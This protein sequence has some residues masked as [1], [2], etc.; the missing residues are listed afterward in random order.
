M[1][2]QNIGEAISI[3]DRIVI[4]TKRPSTV[5]KVYKITFE[6]K[7]SPTENRKEKEF[8]TYYNQLWKEIDSNVQ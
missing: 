1:D 6:N 7:K 2:L 8:E 5:K 4:L 3:S